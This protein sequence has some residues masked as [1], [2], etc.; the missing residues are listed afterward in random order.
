MAMNER[1]PVG[2][3]I[4][5]G[6]GF[7]Y[8]DG[9]FRPVVLMLDFKGPVDPQRLQL[10]VDQTLLAHP[11]AAYGILQRDGAFFC[12]DGLPRRITVCTGDWDD[13]P[14]IG[15]KDADGHL[16]GVNYRDNRVAVTVFHGLTDG[17]GAMAFVETMLRA[18]AALSRGEV[19]APDTTRYGDADAEPLAVVND[20]FERMGLPP[21][22]V[23]AMGEQR[24][25]LV[26]ASFPEAEDRPCH[27]LILANAA[28]YMGFAKRCGARPAAVLTAACVKAILNVM[29]ETEQNVRVA[30]PADF[31]QALEIPHTFR[32]CAMPPL[33]IEL[34][35]ETANGPIEGLAQAVQAQVNRMTDRAAEVMAVKAVAEHFNR[36]PPLPYSQAARMFAQFGNRPMFTFNASYVARLPE[37]DWAEL[38][39]TAYF[40]N[41][42]ERGQT[43][44]TAVALPDRFC[45]CIN[46]G[47]A[48]RRYADALCGVLSRCGIANS[49]EGALAGNR[50]YVALR[51]YEHW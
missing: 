25:F 33:M 46:Q 14:P 48:T 24:P 16:L 38:L 10:A 47:E 27:Y 26:P 7:M 4:L 1:T 15:G 22:D 39:E 32:N 2:G 37:G 28:D 36:M 34:D 43:V 45:F 50:G 51:E 23:D 31:R 17:R 42:S 12:H 11:W 29:G 18:Y 41:P 21:M 44:I 3:P 19:F 5:S 49:L 6:K 30:I 8:L 13:L 40:L 35:P 9:Y 20:I